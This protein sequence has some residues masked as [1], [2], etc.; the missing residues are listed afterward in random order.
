MDLKLIASAPAKRFDAERK[1]CSDG[2]GGWVFSQVNVDRKITDYKD[3]WLVFYFGVLVESASEDDCVEFTQL[4]ATMDGQEIG[5]SDLEWKRPNS[6]WGYDNG[7]AIFEF[8]QAIMSNQNRM[9]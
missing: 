5:S 6:M 4:T 2:R 7:D 3:Y 9:G 1:L 8:S